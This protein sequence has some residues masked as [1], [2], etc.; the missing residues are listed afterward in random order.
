MTFLEKLETKPS[1]D[2]KSSAGILLAMLRDD[3]TKVELRRQ[4]DRYL[5]VMDPIVDLLVRVGDVSTGHENAACVAMWLNE[6]ETRLEGNNDALSAIAKKSLQKY[7]DDERNRRDFWEAVAFLEPMRIT[8]P[9]KVMTS[10]FSKAVG[11]DVPEANWIS[12]VKSAQSAVVPAEEFWATE[13]H[14]PTLGVLVDIGR[15]LIRAPV[16]VLLADSALS[17]E[18]YLLSKRRGH[19]SDHHAKAS[20][21]LYLNRA[22]NNMVFWRQDA[23][24]REDSHDE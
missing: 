10:Q 21:E 1:F 11:I 8:D 12:F 16:N 18:D 17:V 7:V 3:R 6:A 24:G 13:D 19:L 9:S 2:G 23:A 15:L 4:L 14:R 22:V 20:L 5:D